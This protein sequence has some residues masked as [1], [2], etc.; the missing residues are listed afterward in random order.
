MIGLT[1]SSSKQPIGF[2]S[3][4]QQNSYIDYSYGQAVADVVNADSDV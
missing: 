4:F 3:L 1:A 2:I